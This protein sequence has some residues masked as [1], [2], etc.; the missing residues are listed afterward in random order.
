MKKGDI[1]KFKVKQDKH[2]SYVAYYLGT[3]KMGHAKMYRFAMSELGEFEWQMEK[4]DVIDVE[5][6]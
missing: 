5:V 3:A 2:D 4:R 1:V 6:L